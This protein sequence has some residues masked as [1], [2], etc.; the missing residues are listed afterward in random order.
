MQ[1]LLVKPNR[2][3]LAIKNGEYDRGISIKKLIERDGNKCYLCNREVEFSNST[4]NPLYPNIE[5]VIPISRG[6][7]HSWSNVK[8][9]CRYCNIH[10]SSMTLEEYLEVQEKPRTS[11][12]EGLLTVRQ[13]ANN[14]K[15]S[16]QTINNNVPPGMEYKKINGMNYINT[17]LALAIEKKIE[18]N[19]KRYNY[20]NNVLEENKY[21]SENQETLLKSEYIEILKEQ[22]EVK[23]KQIESY[24]EVIGGLQETLRSM[25]IQTEQLESALEKQKP[26][27]ENWIKRVFNK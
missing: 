21:I 25:D 6:G 11:P 8:V 17:E 12:T 16:K 1:K 2:K 23:D 14:L 15:V 13:L 24:Y 3:Q 19:R 9:A 27:K 7:T 26:K 4:I 22:I 18:V 20:E 5:H 10:K